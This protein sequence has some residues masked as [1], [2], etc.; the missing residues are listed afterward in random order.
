MDSLSTAFSIPSPSEQ[1]EACAAL[2]FNPLHST[3][4][5]TVAREGLC[6]QVSNNTLYS[7]S[8]Y[9]FKTKLADEQLTYQDFQNIIYIVKQLQFG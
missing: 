7:T 5:S 4:P 9:T 3:Y 1:I 8:S 2:S 6:V